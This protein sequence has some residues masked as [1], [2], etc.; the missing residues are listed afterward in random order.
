M[1]QPTTQQHVHLSQNKH[2]DKQHVAMTKPQPAQQSHMHS[3]PN[4]GQENATTSASIFGSLLAL[5]GS[6]LLFGRKRKEQ[7]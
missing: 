4:T 6:I 3:L 7:R 2:E 5:G 1:A